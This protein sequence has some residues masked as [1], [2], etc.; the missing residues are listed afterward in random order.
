LIAL[1]AAGAVA[2]CCSWSDRQAKLLP[3]ALPDLARADPSVQAQT[4]EQYETLTRKIGGRRTPQ[5]ELASAYGQYG[6]LLQAARYF[7]AA[8]PCYLNAKMLEA[9]EIRWP[10]YLAHLYK[11]R[12]E[13]DRAE[14]AFREVLALRA[15]D[16][17]AIIWL[18]RLLLDKGQPEEAEPL[19]AKAQALMP[20]SVAALAG[21]GQANLARRDFADAARR[22]E[23]AL[24]IDPAAES[25]HSPLA[26]AY[27]GL[28]QLD[29]AAPHLRQWKN[30]DIPLADPLLQE[31]D[32]LL[33]SGLSYELR[34][35]RALDARDFKGAV[36]FF[37]KGVELTPDPSPLRRSLQHKLGTALYMTGQPGA[38]AE[39]FDAVVREAPAE[40]I[41]ESA[42]KAHY[43]LGVLEASKGR[44]AVA[45]EHFAAAVRFQPNYIEARLAL[46]DAQR[47][48]GRAEESLHEYEE[49]L[50]INPRAVQGRLGYAMSLVALRRYVRARD[51]LDE[52]VRLQPDEP[53]LSHALA[54]L[55]V[56]APDAAVRD[57]H[58]AMAIVQDL[59]KAGRRT[60]LGETMAMAAAE[61][62]NFEE[63]AAIQRGVLAAAER[64]GLDQAARRMA[65]NLALYEHGQPSRTPW[66]DDDLVVLPSLE[67]VHPAQ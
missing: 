25:L 23:E 67:A 17:P 7:D 57:G 13:T 56:T 26:M 22:F 45:R 19:F 6:M 27:R 59:M 52:S 54:R 15:D 8:E 29:K 1:V 64:A 40:A 48:I 20:R 31:L 63:A 32:L 11:S 47:R 41:D 60:D 28:G 38:A 61:L 14:A 16:F 62:G 33:E 36:A 39:Q 43:S 5:A 65:R 18:G 46:A 2:T 4:R 42:A 30:T 58:R 21:L 35:V 53:L 9:E 34:G 55:L 51:W 12:G 10:Y 49:A 3:I 50:R 66:Q 24:A 44:L 37:R